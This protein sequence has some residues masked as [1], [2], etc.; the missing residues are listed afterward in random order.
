MS[1]VVGWLLWFPQVGSVLHDQSTR[2]RLIIGSVVAD[3][4]TELSNIAAFRRS[5]FYLQKFENSQCL[6]NLSLIFIHV[7]QSP[8]SLK[9]PSQLEKLTLNQI[10]RNIALH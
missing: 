2:A 5:L 1:D 3:E 4:I 7:V 9:M 8:S 6:Y 10:T